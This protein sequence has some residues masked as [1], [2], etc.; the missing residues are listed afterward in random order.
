[1]TVAQKAAEEAGRTPVFAAWGGVARGMLAVADSAKPSSRSAIEALR[2]LGPHPI[3]LT[4]DNE[5]TA[6]A[7]AASVGIDEVIAE[8]LPRDKV[9]VVKRLQADRRVVA[10][11]G[12]GVNDAV[13]LAQA[14]LGLAIGTGTDVAIEASDLTPVS[15]DLRAAADA[16]R[17]SRRPVPGG[18]NPVRPARGQVAAAAH[19]RRFPGRRRSPGQAGHP[20]ADGRGLP[21]SRWPWRGSTDPGRRH[22]KPRSTRPHTSERAAPSAGPTRVD[23]PQIST[24]GPGEPLGRPP[25]LGGVR[26]GRVPADGGVER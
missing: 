5:R 19:R 10:M 2:G 15:G 12:D 4:G 3:L 13:A 16:I 24:S 1:M 8:V 21:R 11:V 25:I 23:L 26:S 20:V 18:R 6:R 7:V 17:L 22:H 14:D 9:D